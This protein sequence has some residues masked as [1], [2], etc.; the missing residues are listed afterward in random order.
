MK[1]NR[2][3]PLKRYARYFDVPANQIV[4]MLNRRKNDIQQQTKTPR[5]KSWALFRETGDVNR[6]LF[7]CCAGE[8]SCDPEHR[9]DSVIQQIDLFT[10]DNDNT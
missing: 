1:T 8:V 9:E 5:E 3:Q 4:D 2:Y 10:I 6:S 7:K